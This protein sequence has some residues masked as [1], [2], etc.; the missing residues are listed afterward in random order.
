MSKIGGSRRSLAAVSQKRRPGKASAAEER[1]IDEG[2]GPDAPPYE[3]IMQESANEHFFKG[4]AKDLEKYSHFTPKN[5]VR[6]TG[7]PKWE[8]GPNR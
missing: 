4:E 8:I 2:E 7:G 1:S 3:I 5:A 6:N